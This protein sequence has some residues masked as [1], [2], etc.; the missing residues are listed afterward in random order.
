MKK[1]ITA[2]LSVGFLITACTPNDPSPSTAA[3][4]YTQTYDKLLQD[5]NNDSVKRDSTRDQKRPSEKVDSVQTV[6]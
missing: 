3:A 2:V 5:R 6:K 1:L 4:D